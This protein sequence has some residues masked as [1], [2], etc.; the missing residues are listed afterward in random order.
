MVWWSAL[1][2]L[3]ASHTSSFQKVQTLQ[4]MP[5]AFLSADSP[6][7]VFFIDC[8]AFFT[9]LKTS[10]VDILATYGVSESSGPHFLVAEDPGGINTG[11][12]NWV[13]QS[14]PC[15]I[16]TGTGE[17]STAQPRVKLLFVVSSY[18]YI[19]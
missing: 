15:H 2:N 18:R 9:D 17:N 5:Q 16:C 12:E 14:V 7:W 13:A 6:D 1:L 3:L 10:L 8:D 19:L 11:T 4:S